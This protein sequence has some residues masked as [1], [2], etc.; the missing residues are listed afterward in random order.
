MAWKP[1]SIEAPDDGQDLK[2]LGFQC[3]CWIDNIGSYDKPS[4][5]AVAI[6]KGEDVHYTARVYQN[7]TCKSWQ[8]RDWKVKPDRKA[9]VFQLEDATPVMVYE[10]HKRAAGRQAVAE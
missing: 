5:F 7:G 4:L 2:V 3:R 1:Y 8:K 9:I 10:L 6:P